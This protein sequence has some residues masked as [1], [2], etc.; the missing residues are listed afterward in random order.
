M[1]SV[2]SRISAV[3]VFSDR[4]RITRSASTQVEPGS[5]AIELSDLP[6][7]LDVESIRCSIRGSA[8]VRFLGVQMRRVFLTESSGEAARHLEEEIE[9]LEDEATG[10][11]NRAERIEHYRGILSSLA[12]ETRTYAKALARGQGDV[13]QQLQMFD[14]L[15]ARRESLDAEALQIAKDERKLQRHL[16]KARGELAQLRDAAPRERY[17]AAVE[18]QVDQGGDVQLDLS[19]VLSGAGWTPLYDLRLLEG[20]QP[21]VELGYL[22][23]VSQRTGEAWE[24]VTLTLST[25]RPALAGTIP[26]LHPWFVRAAPPPL[27]R[28]QSPGMAMA[29]APAPVAIRSAV[30]EQHELDALLEA[31]EVSAQ[32]DASSAAVTYVIPGVVTIPPDGG[33]HR[34]TVARFSLPPRLDYVIAAGIIEAAY[35]RARILN[36]SPYLLLPGSANLFV[37]EEFVGTTHMELTAPQAELEVFLGVDDR[38]R[39]EREMKRRE[40]DRRLLGGRSV[41]RYGYEVTVENLLSRDADVVVHDQIPVSRQDDIQVKLESAEPGPTEQTELNLLRWELTLRSKEKRLVRFDFAVESP[42]G[43]PV[44]GLP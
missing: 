41:L 34:V 30:A 14:T 23:L 36:D 44:Q 20:E 10:L 24:N 1:A 18:I 7:H 37:G 22:A 32:V 38:L 5:H 35:R 42:R 15:G 16:E 33:G 21:L 9:R 43:M 11:H 28:M 17:T 8:R 26:E 12:E 25:A 19:Y 31:E 4:A 13:G 2:Y 27:P 40:A 29:A 6:L 39:V 3:T